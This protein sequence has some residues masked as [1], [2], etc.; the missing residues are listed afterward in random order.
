MNARAD[1]APVEP[2]VAAPLVEDL[3]RAVSSTL[4]SYRLYA[5]N[6]PALD[7]FVQALRQKFIALW[8]HLPAVRLTVSESSLTWE[9]ERVYPSGDSGGDL[10]FLF[11]KDGIREITFRPGVENELERLLAALS[12]APLLRED[13]DD[14][15]TLLWHEDLTSFQYQYVDVTPEGA[16]PEPAQRA[17]AARLDPAEVRQ[18]AKEPSPGLAT[19]DFQETLY[20]LDEGELRQL[21][22][23]VRHEAARDLWTDVLHALFDRLEDGDGDRKLRVVRIL[24][25][26]LPP[27]LGRADFARAAWMLSQLAELSA[28]PGLLGLAELREVRGLYGRLADPDTIAELARTL[29]ASPDAIQSEGL[30]S[31]MAFFPPHALAPLTRAVETVSRPDVRRVLEAAVHRLAE[32]NRDEVVRLL[33][34]PDP[35]VAAGAAR[36]VGTLRI[37]SAVGDVVPLLRRP[38]PAVRLAAIAALVELGAAVAGAPMTTL[39]HDPER[40]VRIAAAR[41]LASLGYTAAGPALEAALE[42]KQLRAADRTEKIAFFEAFGALGGAEGAAALGKMLNSRGWLG[43]GESP[44]IRACAALGLARSHHPAARAALSRAAD[45][46]DPV[47]KS[48]VARALR[49][50]AP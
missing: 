11:Y 30:A 21:A 16:E 12:R 46:P 9:G 48:A 36:A 35:G 8:E 20:F 50:P 7:R 29:E 24:A 37:G 47:V 19:D 28:R 5:G 33:G 40:E 45:D 32:S 25:E 14:L 2:E 6:G 44:E 3:L 34:D 17:P 42:S 22:E 23:E 4:R 13:E 31:L 15:I 27:I 49:E 18:A 10:A 39:L 38:E 1:Q 43:R 26:L 41:A